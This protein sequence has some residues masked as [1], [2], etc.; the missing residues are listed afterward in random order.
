MRILFSRYHY[1]V[2]GIIETLGAITLLALVIILHER[3]CIRY[4]MD[5]VVRA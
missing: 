5:S 4:W 2:L 3:V 1:T